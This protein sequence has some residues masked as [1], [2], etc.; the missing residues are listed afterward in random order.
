MS[1]YLSQTKTLF[2][3]TLNFENQS[4]LI[5]NPIINSVREFFKNQNSLSSAHLSQKALK[6]ALSQ[7]TQV[8]EVEQQV[9]DELASLFYPNKVIYLP[10]DMAQ[11]K[12]GVESTNSSN[13]P[14]FD[15]KPILD[16]Q[17]PQNISQHGPKSI[18]LGQS[19]VT[20]SDL[21]NYKGK[22]DLAG[23]YYKLAGNSK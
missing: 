8:T 21:L 19:E 2:L 13:S 4:Y 6:N 10:G 9:R 1:P 14:I 18:K 17:P 3:P 22:G 7:G 23:L 11:A 20:P 15:K 16:E 12:Y 5:I